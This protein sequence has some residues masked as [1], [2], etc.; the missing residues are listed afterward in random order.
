MLKKSLGT[1]LASLFIFNSAQGAWAEE[2]DYAAD[3]TE[4]TEQRQELEKAIV[5]TEKQIK[6]LTEGE[7]TKSQQ[8]AKEKAMNK[9]IELEMKDTRLAAYEEA[10]Q[11]AIEMSRQDSGL[12]ITATFTPVSLS[13]GEM[14]PDEYLPYYKSAQDRYGVDW[15]VLAA[16]HNVET[17]FSTHSTMVSSVGAIG[18]MQFMPAT[19]ASYGVDGDGDGKADAWNVQDAI[20]SAA[21]Y[22]SASGYKKDVRKAIWH[23]NH[24]EWYVN[25][26]LALADKYKAAYSTKAASPEGTAAGAAQIAAK[27]GEKW[28]GNTKYVW[29]GGRTESSIARGDFDCSSF[30]YWAY[31]TAGINI[32]SPGNTD[33]LKNIG[34]RIDVSEIKVGDMIFWDTYKKD[35]HVGIYVGNGEWIGSQSSTGV[36]TVKM[37]NPYWTKTFKGHVRRVVE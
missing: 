1:C 26:V 34:R 14:V 11:R 23:Y 28:V 2:I 29:G 22:L 27:V 20:Y 10:Y 12:N 8:E 4:I 9:R 33:T 3:K 6:E 5:A 24:A 25:K 30:V 15:Y 31:N 36:A 32:G 35:G 13:P 16:V 21:N 19:F 7:E 17:K 18:H 37:D